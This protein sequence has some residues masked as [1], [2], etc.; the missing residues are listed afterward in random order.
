MGLYAIGCSSY[1]SDRLIRLVNTDNGE[2]KD[3][4]FDELLIQLQKGTIQIEKLN[5]P[6]NCTI[7]RDVLKRLPMISMLDKN[8]YFATEIYIDKNGDSQIQGIK[9]DGTIDYLNIQQLMDEY[10]LV[11]TFYNISMGD[12][13]HGY[14]T[15]FNFY[16]IHSIDDTGGLRLIVD[17]LYSLKL[18]IVPTKEFGRVVDTRLA[19]LRLLGINKG[20]SGDPDYKLADYYKSVISYKLD[21]KINNE[22]KF[23]YNHKDIDN[24]ELIEYILNDSKANNKFKTIANEIF[25]HEPIPDCLDKLFDKEKYL[26]FERIDKSA[27]IQD[28]AGSVIYFYKIESPHKELG[29]ICG[30]EVIVDGFVVH[31]TIIGKR[32]LDTGSRLKWLYE[33]RE[34]IDKNTSTDTYNKININASISNIFKQYNIILYENNIFVNCTIMPKD[35]S[36]IFIK[37][38]NTVCIAL[39]CEFIQDKYSRLSILDIN[40]NEVM[41]V[42]VKL[43][44]EFYISIYTLPLEMNILK[45]ESIESIEDYFNRI[46]KNSIQPDKEYIGRVVEALNKSKG[47]GRY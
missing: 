45:V 38:I 20:Y 23:I 17:N 6:K 34:A 5:T 11:S 30:A 35:F 33:E 29:N 10:R 18:K 27:I 44:K 2:V 26:G 8:K 13:V 9:L 16:D 31:R 12:P 47:S 42:I 19:K 1:E 28:G 41:N 36:L 37:L 43:N 21:E 22:T 39:N 40:S 7:Y 25:S 24:Y 32:R 3:I 14:G 15:S 4:A 46:R